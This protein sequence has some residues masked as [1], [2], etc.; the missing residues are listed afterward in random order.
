MLLY[1]RVFVSFLTLFFSLFNPISASSYSEEDSHGYLLSKDHPLQDQLREL[2]KN[3]EMFKSR[4]G[5]KK[6]GFQVFKRMNRDLMIASHLSIKSYMFKKFKNNVPLRHQLEN[7]LN[8]INGSRAVSAFI[9]SN[10]LRHIIVPRK[11]LYPLP[12]G[13]DDPETGERSF[14]LIVE[15]IDL[16]CHA[17]TQKEEIASMYSNIDYD[18]LKELCMVLYT[19]R[20]LD[21][22]V[23]NMPFTKQGQIAFVDTERW[24]WEREGYLHKVMRYLDKERQDYALAI[25]EQLRAQDQ[26]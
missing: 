19:F 13:F 12:E 22:T 10:N 17:G 3:R 7:Y 6:A 16:C 21:S 9:K 11:W 26:R 20:G 14:V 18:V 15:K 1:I 24:N 4:K 25:F 5:F 8:R 23:F 2:F